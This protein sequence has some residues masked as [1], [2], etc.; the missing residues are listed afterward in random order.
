[1]YKA[2]YNTFRTRIAPRFLFEDDLHTKY[3]EVG[4]SFK[5]SRSGVILHTYNTLSYFDTEP[6]IQNMPC[7]DIRYG[8]INYKESLFIEFYIEKNFSIFPETTYFV[9]LSFGV[10]VGIFVEN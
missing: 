7:L 4:A 6:F 10:C 2:K 8:L 3:L 5:H 9:P 1:M